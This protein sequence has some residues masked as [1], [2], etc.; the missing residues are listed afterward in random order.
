MIIERDLEATMRDGIVL[1]A[2][3]YRPDRE[4]RFPTVL[5]RS[6][7]PLENEVYP[8]Q[9]RRLTEAGYL[10]VYQSVRGRYKSDGELKMGFFSGDV[11]DAEDGYDTVEW[12]AP[13]RGRT[14]GSV[15]TVRRMTAGHSG[16]WPIRGRL[17][18]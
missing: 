18:W 16:G 15:H 6:L 3:A 17:P 12:A 2:N 9:A 8:E 10:V 11:Y 7:Y 5:V 14:D 13:C 4:G 1:R